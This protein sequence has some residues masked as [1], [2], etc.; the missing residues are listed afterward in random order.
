M[1]LLAYFKFKG[2]LGDF[3]NQSFKKVSISNLIQYKIDYNTKT[4][5]F[6]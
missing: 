1:K 2:I 4:F 6:L 3:K 5:L